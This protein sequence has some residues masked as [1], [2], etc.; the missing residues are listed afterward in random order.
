MQIVMTERQE[1]F[2][3]HILMEGRFASESDVLDE[4]LRLLEVKE[5]ERKLADLRAMI[6]ESLKDTRI[7]SEEEMDEALEKAEHELIALGYPE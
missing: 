1:N 2:I 4:S 3:K 6:D 5:N 7:V